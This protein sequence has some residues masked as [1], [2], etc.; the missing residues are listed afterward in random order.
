M[1]LQTSS[2]SSSLSASDVKVVLLVNKIKDPISVH[3][4]GKMVGARAGAGTLQVL[5]G[6]GSQPGYVPPSIRRTDADGRFQLGPFAVAL[7]TL[8]P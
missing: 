8:D 6:L 7:L 4:T 2:S 1:S 3:L 5:E